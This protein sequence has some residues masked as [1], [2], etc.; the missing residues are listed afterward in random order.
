M[1]AL[2]TREGAA[3]QGRR[4][5]VVVRGRFDRDF[6]IFVIPAAALEERGEP[7][8]SS[9]ALKAANL[10][11]GGLRPFCDIGRVCLSDAARQLGWRFAMERAAQWDSVLACLGG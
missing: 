2:D 8:P 4:W 7:G 6:P 5:E 3:G 11:D 9:S 10:T 1:S